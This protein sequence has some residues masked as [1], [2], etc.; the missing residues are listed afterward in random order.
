MST[1]VNW[2]HKQCDSWLYWPRVASSKDSLLLWPTYMLVRKVASIVFFEPLLVRGVGATIG[3]VFASVTDVSPYA[4][5]ADIGCGM[6]AAPID[7]LSLS[8]LRQSWKKDIQQSIKLAIPT[9][10]DARIK[11]HRKAERI[12]RDLGEHTTYLQR[13][14]NDIT[15][16]QVK[17]LS[18]STDR[19]KWRF[20]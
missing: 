4:V 17:Q 7:R 8:N 15:R 13:Q 14:I 6:I 10:H 12:L 5:G 18:N 1:H 2:N 11:A 20:S 16:R 9:G 3:T 19:T